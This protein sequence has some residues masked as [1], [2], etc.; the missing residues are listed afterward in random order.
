[1]PYTVVTIGALVT[2]SN[3]N[4]AKNLVASTAQSSSGCIGVGHLDDASNILIYMTSSAGITTSSGVNTI[5]VSMFDPFDFKSTADMGVTF[6]Q[7][8]STAFY[9]I[10]TGNSS[11]STQLSSGTAYIIPNIG[12]KGITINCSLSSA[13]VDG[14]IVAWVQKQVTV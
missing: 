3:P 11:I 14:E 1:M 6:G 9:P 10:S 4:G 8:F 7:N 2:S 13:S 12:F 5:R